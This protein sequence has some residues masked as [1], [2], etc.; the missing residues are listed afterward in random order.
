VPRA[1][2]LV[3]LLL[4]LGLSSPEALRLRLR[5]AVQGRRGLRAKRELAAGE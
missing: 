3:L 4:L 5:L 2:R 1:P